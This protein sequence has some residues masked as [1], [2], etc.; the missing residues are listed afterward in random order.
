MI[1]RGPLGPGQSPIRIPC[2]KPMTGSAG[3]PI[4][5]RS[6]MPSST[7]CLRSF[8]SC[9]GGLQAARECKDENEN[10]EFHHLDTQTLAAGIPAKG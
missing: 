6:Q 1:P 2:L 7:G 8:G 9:H 3:L 5:G 10:N 4:A